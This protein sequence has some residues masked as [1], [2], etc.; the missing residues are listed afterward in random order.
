MTIQNSVIKNIEYNM[1]KNIIVL[2]IATI[3]ITMIGLSC[4]NKPENNST[5]KT[6]VKPGIN[7]LLE[8]KQYWIEEQDENFY[9]YIQQDI[10]PKGKEK[11]NKI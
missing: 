6:K 4:M 7:V 8:K 1:A 3:M 11:G 2:F 5:P 9:Y 10:G